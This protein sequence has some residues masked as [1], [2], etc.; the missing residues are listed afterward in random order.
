ML[1]NNLD[2]SKK[3]IGEYLEKSLE[4][5]SE[6]G[7]KVG[8]DIGIKAKE[9]KNRGVKIFKDARQEVSNTVKK[10]FPDFLN[11]Y[12]FCQW[13]KKNK[14][15]AVFLY[16]CFESRGIIFK[17]L[18]KTAGGH[19][20]TQKNKKRGRKIKTLK[21]KSVRKRTLRLSPM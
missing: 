21:Y 11:F 13:L 18:L 14:K 1:G 8:N 10:M 2:S 12:A 7:K 19:L 16:L 15:L 6:K 9:L 4:K 5:I 3:Q 20:N 17:K